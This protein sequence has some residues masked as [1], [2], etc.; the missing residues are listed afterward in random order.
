MKQTNLTQ[1]SIVQSGTA[2]R[3]S[4]ASMVHAAHVGLDVHQE[5]IS[6][7]IAEAGRQE[8]EFRG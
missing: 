5:S 6:V 7:A 2:D 1:P 4:A 8:P 3:L